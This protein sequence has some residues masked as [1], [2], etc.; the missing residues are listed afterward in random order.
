MIGK[1]STALASL[2]VLQACSTVQQTEID[3]QVSALDTCE[4]I[5]AL[6]AGHPKGF[7]NLR[8]AQTTSKYMDVWKARYHLVGDSCQVWGWGNGKFS[9]VC[10]LTEPNKAVAMEH[11]D[12]AKEVTQQCLGESWSLKQ[13]KRD[14]GEGTKAEYSVSGRNTVVTIVAASSPTLFATEWK[15]YYFVGD[16]ADLK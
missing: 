14:Q 9:Y 6:V 12:Q 2:V 1:F 13:G 5:D 11:F 4:K 8:T 7:P 16:A 15:T 10:S 3:K